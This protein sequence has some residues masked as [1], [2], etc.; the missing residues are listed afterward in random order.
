MIS[1]VSFASAQTGATSFEDKIKQPQAYVTKE[2]PQAATKINGK[3]KK[4]SAGKIAAKLAIAAVAI[5]AVLAGVSKKGI[6]KVNPDGN[7]TLNAIKTG[8]NT[9]GNWIFEKAVSLK[10]KVLPKAQEHIDD[11]A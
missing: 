4:G 8:I 9:A 5:A 11:L 3:E 6:L 1:S 2:A 7:K 10:D